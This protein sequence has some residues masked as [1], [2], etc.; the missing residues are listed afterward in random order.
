MAEEIKTRLKSVKVI[1]HKYKDANEV[2]INCGSEE[3]YKFIEKAINQTPQGIID[4]S[5]MEYKSHIGQEQ[6]TIE[7]GFY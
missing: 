7:F 4:A 1:S 6:Y 3:V 5:Q 2:L